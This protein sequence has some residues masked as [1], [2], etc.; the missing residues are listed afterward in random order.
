MKIITTPIYNL[1]LIGEELR[2][3]EPGIAVFP[4]GCWDGSATVPKTARDTSLDY[5]VSLIGTKKVIES[6]DVAFLVKGGKVI[7]VGVYVRD[8]ESGRTS[9]IEELYSRFNILHDISPSEDTILAIVKQCSSIYEPVS[10]TRAADLIC[11]PSSLDHTLYEETK[12]LIRDATKTNLISSTLF[13]QAVLDNFRGT[14]V[15]T[16]PSFERAA[17]TRT[18]GYAVFD[19]SR[20]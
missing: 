10:D 8:S 9:S 5:R 4:E 16:M 15:F 3:N 11:V 14:D 12:S 13:V 19:Y 1:E 6:F 7:P 18:K 2:G 20:H 17:T